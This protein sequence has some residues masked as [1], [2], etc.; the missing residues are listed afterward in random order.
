MPRYF[1]FPR[2][3]SLRTFAKSTCVDAWVKFSC[4]NLASFA[5]WAKYFLCRQKVFKNLVSK[6]TR[7]VS[8]T[9]ARP[10][11]ISFPCFRFSTSP[12]S[13]DSKIGLQS[14]Q[15]VF[16]HIPLKININLAL[17]YGTSL[18]GQYYKFYF[19]SLAQ[20]RKIRLLVARI[21]HWFH[22]MIQSK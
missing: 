12:S 1:E 2:G 6:K 21:V 11:G 8:G 5:G 13:S 7:L 14:P 10:R 19:C 16:A 20:L 9:S 17:S 4:L 15:T 22:S 18:C 3:R